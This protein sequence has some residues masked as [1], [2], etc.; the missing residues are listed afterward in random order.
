MQMKYPLIEQTE[1][2]GNQCFKPPHYESRIHRNAQR[3]IWCYF[4]MAD[5]E[6]QLSGGAGAYMAERRAS[7]S[8]TQL[9][10]EVESAALVV[11]GA[12]SLIMSS[13]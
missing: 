2:T 8:H 4:H 9:L 10:T 6:E 1:N 13:M 11:A 12:Y 3:N 5:A 7:R